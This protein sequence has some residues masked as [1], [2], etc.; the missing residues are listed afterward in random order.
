MDSVGEEGV[1]RAGGG[2]G[3]EGGRGLDGRS[4]SGGGLGGSLHSAR[5]ECLREMSIL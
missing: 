2:G 3:D 4:G 1:V 5:G